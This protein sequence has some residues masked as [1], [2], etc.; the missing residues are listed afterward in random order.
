MTLRL[1]SRG[2]Q[3]FQ[4]KLSTLTKI[5]KLKKRFVWLERGSKSP[6]YV[7]QNIKKRQ[8]LVVLIVYKTMGGRFTLQWVIGPT[9]AVRSGNIKIG[10]AV[11]QAT[12]L[13]YG[14]QYSFVFFFRISFRIFSTWGSNKE[15]NKK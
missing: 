13:G 4:D 7:E 11:A 14:N 6:E 12:R 5:H 2:H 9:A 3:Q 8:V 10:R 15:F 1:R